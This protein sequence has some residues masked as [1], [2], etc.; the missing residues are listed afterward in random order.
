MNTQ[1][2]QYSVLKYRPSLLLDEQVN[3]GLLFVFIED[4]RVEFIFPTHLARL[5]A[6]YPQTDL[7][8]I[9]AHFKGFKQKAADLSSKSSSIKDLLPALI[10]T[11]FLQPDS[12][13]LYFTDFKTGTYQQPEAII[14]HYRTEFFA[15][16]DDV[17]ERT[18]ADKRIYEEDHY[19]AY[20]PQTREAAQIAL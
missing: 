5:I 3:I 6:L 9:R 14:A 19:Q 7:S 17:L 8:L 11:D 1:F 18:T 15:V 13:S 10:K 16:Y 12:N 2:Y 4:K 20:L